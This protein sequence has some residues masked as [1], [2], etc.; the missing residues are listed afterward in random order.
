VSG[1]NQN[2]G[3]PIST[4]PITV[5]CAN[6][7]FSIRRFQV[8]RTT[9]SPVILKEK[10]KH[11]Y[12]KAIPLDEIILADGEDPLPPEVLEDEKPKRH[13]QA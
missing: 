8:R 11:H 13:L 5:F 10:R 2:T 6:H 9:G 12:E 1:Y 7:Y 3:E 4:W